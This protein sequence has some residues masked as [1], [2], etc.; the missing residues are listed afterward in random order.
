MEITYKPDKV[1]SVEGV[2]VA[3]KKTPEWYTSIGLNEV[4]ITEFEDAV[5]ELADKIRGKCDPW[6]VKIGE[7]FNSP[8]RGVKLSLELTTITKL[9]D[10]IKELVEKT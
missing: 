1:L 7:G 9:V 8:M 3:F 6:Q 10:I 2:D 5:L 4:T